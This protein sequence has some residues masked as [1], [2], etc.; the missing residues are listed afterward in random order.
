MYTPPKHSDDIV[1][2]KLIIL[3]RIAFS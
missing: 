3:S 1:G 2:I